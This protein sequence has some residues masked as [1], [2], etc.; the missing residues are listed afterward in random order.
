[1]EDKSY[2][3]MKEEF[4]EFY[5]NEVKDRLAEYNKFRRIMFA[6]NI[7]IYM[8]SIS[9]ILLI[10]ILLFAAFNDWFLVPEYEDI[11]LKIFYILIG[12]IICCLIYYC[13]SK[14]IR[15]EFGNSI[16]IDVEKGLKAVLMPK[17]INIFLKENLSENFE[18]LNSWRREHITPQLKKRLKTHQ[19][20]NKYFWINFDDFFT[21]KYKNITL[22]LLEIDTRIFNA[23][24]AILIPF[25]LL[26]FACIIILGFVLLT[27]ISQI[28]LV[29]FILIILITISLI[30]IKT[31]QHAS[32]R[33]VIISFEFNKL[34]KGHTFFHEN[35]LRAKKIP[36]DKKKY[37]KVN[38]ESVT[39]EKKY[40]V[41][42][43]DQ[44]EAR[45]LFTT[46]FI[47]RIEN[48]SFAFKAKYVRGSFKDDKL[49]LAIHTGKD[50]FA[51]GSDSKDTDA[52]TFEILFDEMISVLQIVD[53]LKLNE[54]M[55]L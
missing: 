5:H 2:S 31:I 23:V 37:K 30:L 27:F 28:L 22:S 18:L 19:I 4:I 39:F 55:G 51:M 17:F 15:Q 7:A 20:F 24:S 50:M 25:L 42:S 21:G 14:I 45:Y 43:D 32:F 38:L 26:Y 13:F 6:E 49:V 40:N 46:A 33:G 11:L 53:A 10:S 54:H 29:F 16:D 48:L 36:F 41:Y 8:S 1:M 34:F 35:S 52:H 9:I 12:I 44:I 47:E 3:Q